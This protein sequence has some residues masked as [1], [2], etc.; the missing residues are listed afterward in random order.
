MSPPECKSSGSRSLISRVLDGQE[1]M[2]ATLTDIQVKVG[3]IET[4]IE[5]MKME[6]VNTRTELIAYRLEHTDERKTN[7]TAHA[8]IWKELTNL[9][10]WLKGM[11]VAWG[12][13][14]VVLTVVM[15]V[16]K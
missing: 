1:T 5:D 14:A 13:L 7:E 9:T 3:C 6:R 12:I 11:T 16:V 4:S 15:F 2:T 10:T 8:D